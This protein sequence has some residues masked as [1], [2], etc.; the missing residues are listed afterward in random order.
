MKR[1][2]WSFSQLLIFYLACIF[3]L[4]SVEIGIEKGYVAGLVIWMITLL[5]LYIYLRRNG[6]YQPTPYGIYTINGT[7]SGIFVYIIGMWLI[8]KIYAQPAGMLQQIKIG[9]NLK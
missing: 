3:V 1:L 7:M 4:S 9:K 2:F 6:R 8:P 5:L